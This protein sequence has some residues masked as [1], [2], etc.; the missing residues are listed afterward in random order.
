MID[1]AK[2]KNEVGA[3]S[4]VRLDINN[5]SCRSNYWQNKYFAAIDDFCFTWNKNC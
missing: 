4:E 2:D 3:D 5:L 1:K